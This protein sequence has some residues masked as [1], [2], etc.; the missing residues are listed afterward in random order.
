[1]PEVK[2]ETLETFSR[3]GHYKKLQ[4]AFQAVPDRR[5][6]NQNVDLQYL[7]EFETQYPTNYDR[8]AFHMNK[9]H[10]FGNKLLPIAA[11]NGNHKIA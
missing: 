6:D 11:Q 5:F 1:M 8:Q 10:L 2:F 3:H 4:E 7:P 9:V